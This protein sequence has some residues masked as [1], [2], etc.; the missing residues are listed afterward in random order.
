MILRDKF[1]RLLEKRLSGVAE[2]GYE[3]FNGLDFR[4]GNAMKTAVFL[5][6]IALVHTVEAG[7]DVA[8]MRERIQAY[9][10][11]ATNEGS[12]L[13][14]VYFVPKDVE[15][16]AGFRE[17]IPRIMEDIQNF[18]RSEMK[19]NGF[20]D[21]VFPLDTVDGKP[22]I[23]V[24]KGRDPASEYSHESGH[25]VV[26]EVKQALAGKLDLSREF[27]LIFNAM[28]RKRE[29]GSYIFH[30]PYSHGR[31]A[32]LEALVDCGGAPLQALYDL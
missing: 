4:K 12:V 32:A 30:A 9:H 27:V 5:A 1:D 24:V 21:I 23:H 25:K 28:C 14:L 7:G 10:G 3:R 18:Y 19:R 17:R 22:R 6:I 2:Q 20:G 26:S 8:Y 15:P 16:Q 29:D 13:H 11:S 31:R